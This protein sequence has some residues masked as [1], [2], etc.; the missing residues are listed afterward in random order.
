MK[1][2]I[3]IYI[4]IYIYIKVQL[5]FYISQSRYLFLLCQSLFNLYIF[6]LNLFLI[7]STNV[8]YFV[9]LLVNN[10]LNLNHVSPCG[11]DI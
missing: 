2:N 9:P 1:L 5:L 3:Y 8:L 11:Y 7:K 4:Y 10:P 6:I